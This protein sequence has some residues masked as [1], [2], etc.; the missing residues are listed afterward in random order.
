MK[1][2]MLVANQIEKFT[3]S[4]NMISPSVPCG[5][6]AL[7]HLSETCFKDDVFKVNVTHNKHPN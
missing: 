4:K 3:F 6:F 7:G 5:D 1:I 2:E